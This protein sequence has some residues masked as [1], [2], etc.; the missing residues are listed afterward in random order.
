MVR[1][2]LSIAT[3]RRVI[4]RITTDSV[5]GSV[6]V[7]GG[8]LVCGLV[9]IDGTILDNATPRSVRKLPPVSVT[10]G[11]VEQNGKHGKARV[12]RIRETI[13]VLSIRS[14]WEV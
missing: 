9:V 2:D 4:V 12:D 13:S 1:G 8:I 14:S 7:N 5:G 11:F 10:S 3:E 6:Y